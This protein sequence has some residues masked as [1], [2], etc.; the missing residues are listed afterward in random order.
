MASRDLNDLKPLMLQRIILFERQLEEHGLKNFCRSC[1]LR[2]QA[3]HD[4]LWMRGRYPLNVV[5]AA[6]RKV[7]LAPITAEENK[8]PVTWVLTSRHTPRPGETKVD[9]VDY[10]Q[11]VK[12]RASYDLKVDSDFDNIPDW[13]EFVKI[14]QM[15]G[16]EAGGAW[17]K[18]DYPHVQ[19]KD[20]L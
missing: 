8:R 5:N 1:V 15:C 16:L 12:G 7:W 4:A 11:L 6:Y 2:S 10:F 20:D 18:K 13:H 14:A 9:A 19:W 3:E 17:Q